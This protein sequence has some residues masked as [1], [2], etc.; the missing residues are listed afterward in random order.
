MKIRLV[1]IDLDGTLLNSDKKVTETT[2]A[3][4]RSARR[5]TGV[6]VVLASARPPRTVRPFHSLLDL[7][8]PMINY[9]GALVMDPCSG[10]VLL[11]RAI[12]PQVAGRVVNFARRTYPGVLVS[13]EIMD[14]WYTDQYDP[15]RDP[16]LTETAKLFEPD[17]VAPLR[18]WINQAITK[19]LLLGEGEPLTEVALGLAGLLGDQVA[20][21]QTE[22]F[23][24]Q[25]MHPQVSKAV[26]LRLVCDEL[27]VDR[28]ETMAIGDNANDVGM[29]QWA[30]VG[31]AV[32]NAVPAALEAADYVSDTND[33]DG[34]AHAIRRIL[35]E[36][37][38]PDSLTDSPPGD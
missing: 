21:V 33:A 1:A 30:K 2:S 27:G 24:L 28:R 32:G 17:V 19:I 9:N 10:R 13:A 16:F 15:S 20:M 23:L 7:D 25:V 12:A 37:H 26:A 22:G 3:I 11:H 5:Q 36:G 29:L 8:T 35:L 38:V 31:V 34:A 18:Q 4:L 14:K 6:H